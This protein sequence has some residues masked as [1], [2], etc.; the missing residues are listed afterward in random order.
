MLWPLKIKI[1]TVQCIIRLD[2]KS[3]AQ[4]KY[5]LITVV[6]QPMSAR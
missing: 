3:Y 6:T 5:P 2:N 1:I 4:A